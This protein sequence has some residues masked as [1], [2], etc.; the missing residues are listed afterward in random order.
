MTRTAWLSA[1]FF[2]SLLIAFVHNWAVSNYVYWHYVWFDVPV[3]YLGG[4]TIGVFA[5]TL[6][7][8]RHSLLFAALVAGVI[9]GWEVFEFALGIPRKSNYWF[10]TSLDVLMG[11]CGAVLAYIAARFTIWRSV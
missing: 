1:A 6:L 8:T 5:V 4:L 3:H 7:K 10:D 2:L 11:T 9:I